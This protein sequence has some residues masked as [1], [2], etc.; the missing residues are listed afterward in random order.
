MIFQDDPHC[1]IFRTRKLCVGA[2]SPHFRRFEI[3]KFGIFLTIKNLHKGTSVTVSSY[4]MY[5]QSN[6]P[7]KLVYIIIMIRSL[8]VF[9]F[10]CRV[11]ISR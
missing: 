11:I 1:K 8:S 10:A 2:S 7:D 6:T 3:K 4:F 9:L 5:I